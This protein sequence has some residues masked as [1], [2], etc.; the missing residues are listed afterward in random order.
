MR[1]SV[2][3]LNK[4]LKSLK[5]AYVAGLVGFQGIPAY[6]ASKHGVGFTKKHH[7]VFI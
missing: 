1:P 7:K 2:I 3:L 4:F 6:T 5:L